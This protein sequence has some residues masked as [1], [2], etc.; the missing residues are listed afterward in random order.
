MFKYDLNK[1]EYKFI[2]RSSGSFETIKVVKVNILTF[3]FE[4]QN[5]EG[6]LYSNMIWILEKMNADSYSR[7]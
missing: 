7:G 4:K 3:N 6:N 5:F 2:F 1:Y